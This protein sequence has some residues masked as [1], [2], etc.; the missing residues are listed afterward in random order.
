MWVLV[1]D[2]G[3]ETRFEL[4]KTMDVLIHLPESPVLRDEGLCVAHAI[5]YNISAKGPTPE[6]ALSR[7]IDLVVVHCRLALE[8]RIDP[9]NIAASSYMT[10][11]FLGTPWR[12]DAEP[13]DINARLSQELVCALHAQVGGEMAMDV[14]DICEPQRPYPTVA[15]F[16]ESAAA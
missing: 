1:F 4:P 16:V 10:A 15:K 3:Q 5:Q 14:R 12:V 13:L 11:F 2:G 7:L 6:I 9:V 8:E